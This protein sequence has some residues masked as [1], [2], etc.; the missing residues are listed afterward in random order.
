MI[1]QKAFDCVNHEIL[2]AKLDFFGIWGVSEDW[3]SFYFTNIKQKVEVKSPNTVQ[4]FFSDW[5]T[6]K[7]GVPQG[8]IL[9]SLLFIIYIN[10]LIWINYVSK[11][12]LFA[13]DTNVTISS[14]NFK[15]FC[16]LSNLVLSHMIKWF[17]ANNLALNLDKMNIMK[18]ITKNLSHSR[19]HISY[20]EKYIEETVN[21]KFPGLQIDN[22]INW[23]KH[24]EEVIPKLSG[25]CYAIRSMDHI[26]NI[27]TLKSIYYAHFHS[28]I[29]YRI[30]SG[31]NS[32]NNGTIFILQKKIFRIA[33]GTQPR[34]P[35]RD[36]FQQLKVLPV[37]CQ[38]ILAL[39]NFINNN[40]EMFQTNGST[41]NI[42]AWNKYHLHRKNS[43]LS[44]FQ[45]ST[46]YV[47]IKIFN[48]LLPSLTILKNDKAQF[49]AA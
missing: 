19:L 44:C 26:S 8:S 18:F 6:L 14:R 25:K 34:T 47:G 7:Y 33:T 39:M 11:I 32:S 38:Y 36:L 21:T 30:I 31:C 2:L 45:K 42:N 29:K 41:H 12:I 23:R 49:K 10:N 22:H 9:G 13:D 20:K 5:D 15:D 28:I 40:Q 43:N 24:I 37:P 46:F 16:S 27:N 17:A 1:W 48:S 3:F 35:C 4:N